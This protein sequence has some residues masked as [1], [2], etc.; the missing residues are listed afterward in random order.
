MLLLVR[1]A[2]TAAT[3]VCLGWLHETWYSSIWYVHVH[4]ERDHFRRGPPVCCYFKD[5][6]GLFTL[7]VAGMFGKDAMVKGG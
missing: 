4:S 3:M 5:L 7:G 2:S 6:I 1:D